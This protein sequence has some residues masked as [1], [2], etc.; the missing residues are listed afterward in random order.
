MWKAGEVLKER[1]EV[2]GELGRG[3]QGVVL[4]VHDRLRDQRVAMKILLT[5]RDDTDQLR[6]LR[7]EVDL[8]TRIRHPGVVPIHDIVSLP[9]HLA[10]TMPWIEGTSLADEVDGSGPLHPE[11]VA[12]LA[13]GLTEVL[14][15]AH[16]QG[17][18]HGDL[19]P[20]N[21]L[22]PPEGAAR[23]TDFGMARQLQDDPTRVGGT[24]GFLAPER[25][26]GGLPDMA[27]DV[28]ALGAVLWFAAT[29][30]T[31][32]VRL[33][34]QP[35]R[36]R[37]QLT[38]RA[39]LPEALCAWMLAALS[40]DP[41]QRPPLIG[42]WQQAQR[43]QS[44]TVSPPAPRPSRPLRLVGWWVLIRS[45]DPGLG[46]LPE[47]ERP[48]RFHPFRL[49]RHRDLKA[50]NPLLSRWLRGPIG[51]QLR[52]AGA[53][54]GRSGADDHSGL[55]VLAAGLS[56][57]RALRLAEAVASRGVIA[58]CVPG[59]TLALHLSGDADDTSHRVVA[60]IP[61]HLTGDDAADLPV[62]R[63]HVGLGMV[64]GALASVP[65]A[66]LASA[67][68]AF[69]LGTPLP[70]FAMAGLLTLL[71][72]SG[73]RGLRSMSVVARWTLA[74]AAVTAAGPW[75][76]PFWH[77]GLVLTVLGWLAGLALMSMWVLRPREVP[78]TM[79]L[80]DL[81]STHD[82][83]T[84]LPILFHGN[85]RHPLPALPTP[86]ARPAAVAEPTV[87]ESAAMAAVRRAGSA[88]QRA[89]QALRGHDTLPSVAVQELEQ[90]LQRLRT[91][92]RQVSD[93]LLADPVDLQG[94]LRA[95]EARLRSLTRR[96][97]G[98]THLPE[99]HPDRIGLASERLEA[100]ATLADLQARWSVH[101]RQLGRL[102]AIQAA[103]EDIRDRLT[104][105]HARTT[106][107]PD[108]LR[109]LEHDTR[110]AL[111]AQHQ[112]LQENG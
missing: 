36:L 77:H 100:R 110:A 69:H 11:R 62:S 25:L 74:A 40:P 82:T 94:R 3:G 72:A 37:A 96:E 38:D 4:L 102:L 24:L 35:D 2:I 98:L 64:F 83:H 46:Y 16:R 13:R 91:H 53:H 71:W 28:Y 30:Q 56:R 41:D 44:P 89:V 7:R 88:L 85:H 79:A 45:E 97:A 81:L 80:T 104:G 49:A 67:G 39:D 66:L 43:D 78:R 93:A 58:A 87:P 15:E 109:R 33:W 84:P 12:R 8:L 111:K 47:L 73:L 92:L 99:S 9:H 95:A 27:A 10:V 57:R 26:E 105:P 5:P 52:L 31:V 112:A 63:P 42:A 48:E 70:S 68:L 51:R 90:Q 17:V 61:P 108:L 54:P 29:G 59:R 18:V 23:L 21:V 14:T 106:S 86:T 76:N 103:A 60:W 32:P 65:V 34:G 1:Y 20:R 75:I 22:L 107:L 50:H 19:T 6:R 55:L 101:Q